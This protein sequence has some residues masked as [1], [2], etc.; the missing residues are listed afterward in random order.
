M[1]DYL[2]EILNIDTG[3]AFIDSTYELQLLNKA[4]QKS[5]YKYDWPQLLKRDADV[6]I[7]N[8]DRYP[9]NSDFRKFR[10]LFSSGSEKEETEFN[11]IRFDRHKYAVDQA[12]DEYVLSERPQTASTPYTLQNSESAG[13]TV[14]VEL[15]TV[16]G[17][18]AG[19]EIFISDTS[20]SEFTQIQTVDTSA[21]TITIK[22]V[23]SH[24]SGKILYRVV[25]LNY[26][27]YYHIITDLS[28]GTDVPALPSNTH[29]IIPHYAA[30]LYYK[31]LEDDAKAKPQLE[32]WDMELAEAWK[33]FDKNSTGAVLTFSV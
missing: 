27:Q 21:E 18:A 26:F 14:V 24:T 25:E 5:A 9:L 8:V 2:E 16:D 11:N 33:A 31:K 15:D 10:F 1:R 32:C 6:L 7:A 30:Y 22:M 19:E 3:D 20:T 17:L 29:F 28:T 23:N 12:T 4:Y 13:S